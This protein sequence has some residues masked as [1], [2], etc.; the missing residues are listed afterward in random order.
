MLDHS[1]SAF[2]VVLLYPIK[3]T[4]NNYLETK[5]M[6][7]WKFAL[8]RVKYLKSLQVTRLNNQTIE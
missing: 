5:K 4:G 3:C 7:S 6:M 2:L 1:G 8:F